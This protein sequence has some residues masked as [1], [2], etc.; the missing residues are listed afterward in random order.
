MRSGSSSV[1]RTCEPFQIL[2]GGS[3]RLTFAMGRSYGLCPS[4]VT[5]ARRDMQPNELV[6]LLGLRPRSLDSAH[7]PWEESLA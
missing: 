3:V 2:L 7:V 1:S 4:T 5:A 6:A